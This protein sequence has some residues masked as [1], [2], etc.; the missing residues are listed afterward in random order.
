M[1]PLLRVGTVVVAMVLIT[2]AGLATGSAS[3]S[4][5]ASSPSSAAVPSP[6]GL[7]LSNGVVSVSFARP[8][9]VL[10]M[11]SSGGPVVLSQALEGLAEVNGSGGITAYAYFD[12]PT[13]NWT[14]GR[15]ELPNASTAQFSA[16]VPAY[17]ASGEW[18][19]GD[20]SG[21]GENQTIGAVN[22]S[23][24]F[25]LNGSAGPSPHT[26]TYV[27]NVSG[28]PW[29]QSNDSLG[30]EV[31]TN[32]SG[33]LGR[34]EGVGASGLRMRSNSANAT[35][36]TFVWS[37]SAVARYGG[38]AAQDSLVESYQNTSG[39]GLDS[40][41]RLSFAMVPGGYESLEFDPWLSLYAVLLS[42]P[43]PAW[44]FTPA[45]LSVLGAGSAVSIALAVYASGRRHPPDRDL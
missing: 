35:Y 7:T 8:Q 32:A 36:A 44:V 28:W 30:L 42:G 24:T 5:P 25:V 3:G 21:D 20:G 14:V 23:I 34:W 17:A 16:T 2:V 19:S 1:P 12:T 15:S 22:V 37:P 39:G 27:L 9:P 38:G 29:Q 45:V 10:T 11:N 26:L 13:L 33:A 40:L 18:E 6:G 43:V 4:V 41:V 31:R